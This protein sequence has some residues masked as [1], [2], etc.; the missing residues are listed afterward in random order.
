MVP[1]TSRTTSRSLRSSDFA[2]FSATSKR[3]V[4]GRVS[5]VP[6]GGRGDMG[7]RRSRP[8]DQ[9]GGTDGHHLADRRLPE[10]RGEGVGRVGERLVGIL[11]HLAEQ[12][13]DANRRG[14]AREGRSEGA[15]AAGPVALASRA[16]DRVGG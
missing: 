16:L 6:D 5:R 13:I 1:S 3:S 15:I 4:R 11:V 8:P 9:K 14:G 7:G 12:G 10:R 2:G